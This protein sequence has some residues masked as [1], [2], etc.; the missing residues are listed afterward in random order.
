V[1]QGCTVADKTLIGMN[2]VLQEGVTVRAGAEGWVMVSFR[3]SLY[4]VRALQAAARGV[5]NAM[6][7]NSNGICSNPACAYVECLLNVARQQCCRQGCTLGCVLSRL[8]LSFPQQQHSQ[9]L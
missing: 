6:V 1:L 8:S 5:C 7:C 3:K 9:Y 4:I 2:A